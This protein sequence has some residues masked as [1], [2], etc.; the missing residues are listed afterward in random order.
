MNEIQEK[1]V[2]TYVKDWLS[3]TFKVV[4]DGGLFR[5]V[6]RVSKGGHIRIVSFVSLGQFCIQFSTVQR[7][8]LEL[9][10]NQTLLYIPGCT[11]PLGE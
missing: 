9:Y 4:G 2:L 5:R 11:E 8:V 6:K 3:F 1:G 10:R 7:R